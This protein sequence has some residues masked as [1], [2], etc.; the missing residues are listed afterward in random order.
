M[1]DTSTKGIRLDRSGWKPDENARS[2][3]IMLG[4]DPDLVWAEFEDYWIAAPGAR[5]V[6]RNW[7][8][9][10]KNWCRKAEGTKRLAYQ[11]MRSPQQTNDITRRVVDNRVYSYVDALKIR[12]LRNTRTG[13][14]DHQRR[15]LE[16][17]GIR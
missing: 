15:V 6:K 9:T 4:L 1:T 11:G 13:I 8:S 5:G 2:F 17:W 16:A 7:F 14:T 10:W 12:E 3:A